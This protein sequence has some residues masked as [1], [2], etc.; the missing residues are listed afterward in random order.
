MEGI[1]LNI[2][3]VLVAA[4]AGI[5]VAMMLWQFVGSRALARSRDASR[6]GKV[7]DTGADVQDARQKKSAT[8]VELEQAGL[9]IS[10]SGFFIIR[11][12]AVAVVLIVATVMGLPGILAIGLAVAAWIVPQSWVRGRARGRAREMEK[13]LPDALA[14]IAALLEIEKDMPTLLATVADGL[15]SANKKS[16]LAAELRATAGEMRA[17][18]ISAAL[19]ALEMRAPSPAV[20]TMAFNLRVF[21]EAGG[22]HV[23]LMREASERMQR[24]IEARN[25]AVAKAGSA[26]MVTRILPGLLVVTTLITMQDPEIRKFYNSVIG[27]M[28]LLVIAAVMAFGYG[29]MKKMVEDAV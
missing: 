22:E 3:P 18:G 17:R 16:A 1:P 20:A 13:E 28:M 7:M 29:F 21:A 2:S 4:L 11:A 8:E 24:I 23:D 12:A 5:W 26:M 14:K 15:E 25:K 19:E 9:N 6:L 10:A 27:Q